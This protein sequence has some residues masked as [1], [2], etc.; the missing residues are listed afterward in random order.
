MRL[1]LSHACVDPIVE[2]ALRCDEDEGFQENFCVHGGID[3]CPC[4]NNWILLRPA[5][6]LIIHAQVVPMDDNDD[7]DDDDDHEIDIL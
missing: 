3:G 4:N 6:H 2:A 1:P 7:D 5:A